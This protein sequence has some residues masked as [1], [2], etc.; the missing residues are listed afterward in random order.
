MIKKL[1]LTQMSSVVFFIIEGKYGENE[2]ELFFNWVDT[3]FDKEPS[4]KLSNA[5]YR[6]FI[7]PENTV[8]TILHFLGKC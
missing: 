1:I 2:F 7:S 4:L 8:F 3:V 5:S 6:Y